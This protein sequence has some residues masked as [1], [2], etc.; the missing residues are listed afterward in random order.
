MYVFVQARIL[1]VRSSDSTFCNLYKYLPPRLG[2]ASSS[3]M[4]TSLVTASI[5][6]VIFT[7]M[8]TW[9]V[10]ALL[11]ML[12]AQY[13]LIYIPSVRQD[14]SQFMVPIFAIIR[15]LVNMIHEG[16]CTQV[17][18][19]CA[20]SVMPLAAQKRAEKDFSSASSE[21]GLHCSEVDIRQWKGLRSSQA[22]PFD[23]HWVAGWLRWRTSF[24][25]LPAHPDIQTFSHPSAL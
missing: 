13:L 16:V 15:G 8:K 2:S 1:Y 25:L 3:A 24:F 23:S 21:S 7:A 11:N 6:R 12:D 4:S 19:V 9:A 22:S 17:A 14:L 20:P 10:V 5:A 18:T